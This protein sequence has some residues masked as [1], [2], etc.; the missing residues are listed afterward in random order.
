LGLHL[1]E[2]NEEVMFVSD[3]RIKNRDIRYAIFT[4][5]VSEEWVNLENLYLITGEDFP[6]KFQMFGGRVQNTKIQLSLPPD[7]FEN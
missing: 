4:G 1:P 3:K 7:F 6:T 2:S 5:S